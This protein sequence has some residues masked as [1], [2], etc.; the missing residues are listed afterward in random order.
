MSYSIM[1]QGTCS[2]AG[3]SIISSGLCRIFFQDGYNVAPFKSQNMALNSYVTRDNL[4]MG[5]AQAVQAMASKIEPDVRMNPIL[6]KPNSDTGSQVIICGKPIGN[7]D[8]KKYKSLKKKLMPIIDNAYKSL[9]KDYE[10]IVIE[11]AGSPADKNLKKD[12]IV[13]SYIAEKTNSPVAI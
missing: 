7:M 12:D 4:E 6:L 11:G 9:C 1:I 2:N 3:K 8:F 13:N 10:L 5:R